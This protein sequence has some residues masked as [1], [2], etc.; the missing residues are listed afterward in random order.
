MHVGEI[1]VDT[2]PAPT[3]WHIC[4]PFACQNGCMGLKWWKWCIRA[5]WTWR[6]IRGLLAGG[7]DKVA[8]NVALVSCDS[9]YRSTIASFCSVRSEVVRLNSDEQLERF[10][11]QLTERAS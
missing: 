1:S 3:S 11:A 9:L 6:R 8:S 10:D 7:G 4:K 5:T 2:K